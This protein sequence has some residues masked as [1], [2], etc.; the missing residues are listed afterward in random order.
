MKKRI[1][2]IVSALLIFAFGVF[3]AT[4]DRTSAESKTAVSCCCCSGDSCPMKSKGETA[5][6]GEKQDCCC[7]GDSC[8][9]KKDHAGA[10]QMN[11]SPDAKT[12]CDCSCCKHDE[13][14]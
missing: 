1:V 2:L 11:A 9:M 3:A 5:A 8:P 12:S 4:Y 14:V 10:M 6:A 13:S 7:K